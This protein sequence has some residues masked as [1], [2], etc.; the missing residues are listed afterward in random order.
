MI[1]RALP[2]FL[3]VWMVATAAGAA[4]PPGLSAAQLKALKARSI[5]PAV[6]GG[7]VS[8][9]ALDPS[10]PSTFYVGPRDRRRHEDRRTTAARFAAIFEKEAVAAIGAVAVAPSDPKVVWVGTGEANDRNSS[11][12][13]NGVYRSTDAGATWTHVGLDGE[14]DDRAHR[15]PP[16]GPEHGLGR[17]DG[18]SLDARRA[19]AASTR[20]PTAARRGRRCSPRPRPTTTAWAAATS[21]SIPSNPDVLYAA[22]YA[23]RRTPWSFTS[24]PD[25]TDGKDLG[26]IFKSTRRRRHL[27]EA[28]RRA[29]RGRT[30]RIGLGGLPRRT[31]G[32]ST[33]SCRATRAGTSDID[34]VREQ[35]RAAC[36]APRTAAR[37]GRARAR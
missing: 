19:S 14:P 21:P 18:R 6:M 7:R 15:R 25:A 20:R 3:A 36:S 24:G 33:R 2:P 10:D 34:D 28:R 22:L 1:R 27:E 30:G 29:C 5:G 31:R 17:G 26:G 4:E 16:E 8:D 12:W 11:S 32:S 37:P 13:G 35:A 23:R 9:I